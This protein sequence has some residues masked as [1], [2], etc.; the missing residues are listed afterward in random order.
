MRHAPKASGSSKFKTI[1]KSNS[2]VSEGLEAFG[3]LWV[4]LQKL[5]GFTSLAE[6]Q[7]FGVARK[8]ETSKSAK[9]SNPAHKGG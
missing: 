1:A 3:V 6:N 7:P 9:I 8:R 5:E 4:A 2:E